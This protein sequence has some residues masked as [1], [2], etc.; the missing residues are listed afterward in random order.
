MYLQKQ[1]RDSQRDERTIGIPGRKAICHYWVKHYNELSENF[2]I[3][4]DSIMVV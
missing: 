2:G 3:D 1:R 4:A